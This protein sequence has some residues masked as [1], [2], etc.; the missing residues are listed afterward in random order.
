M[1]R[2]SPLFALT[3]LCVAPW[4]GL[5][6]AEPEDGKLGAQAF[7]F[8]KKYCAECHHG[9][10][11]ASGVKDYD[12]LDYD[13]LT[14]KRTKK[15]KEVFLVKAG[16]KGKEALE[17]SRV[18]QRAGVEKQAGADGDMPPDDAMAKPTDKEREEVLRKWLEAG[19]PAW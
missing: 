7:A 11:P 13:S 12:V 6:S 5:R 2:L 8:L 19:A 4:S 16:T 14:K 10:T 3:V 15:G 18:W 17:Q 1:N 9:P